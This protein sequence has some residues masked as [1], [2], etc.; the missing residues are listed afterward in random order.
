MSTKVQ[1]V[2]KRFGESQDRLIDAAKGR[3]LEVLAPQWRCADQSIEPLTREER[4]LVL[5]WQFFN[6][7]VAAIE[8]IGA[9]APDAAK[10]AIAAAYLRADDE[11]GPVLILPS[12]EK[13]NVVFGEGVDRALKPKEKA[14]VDRFLDAFEAYRVQIARA[15]N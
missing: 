10:E 15:T 12:A 11:I 5:R 9:K 4:E 13:T 6:N 8:G 7:C 2:R 3:E 14:A 1:Q